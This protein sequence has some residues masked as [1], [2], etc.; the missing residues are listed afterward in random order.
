MNIIN[1]Q[2]DENQPIERTVCRKPTMIGCEI[3][4]ETIR[5]G[6]QS[7][8]AVGF[9]TWIATCFTTLPSFNSVVVTEDIKTTERGEFTRREKQT[10]RD[11]TRCS[12][13]KSENYK[14]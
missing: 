14:L 11:N 10:T 2:V 1:L 3:S 13:G 5:Q 9:E 4:G 8:T 12:F 7:D 6:N